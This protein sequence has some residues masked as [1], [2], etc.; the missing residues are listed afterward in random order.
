MNKFITGLKLSLANS[1]LRV[2]LR[3][4]LV[5]ARHLAV[6]ARSG[7]PLLDSVFLLKKQTSSK[8]MRKI[9]QKVTLDLSNGQFLSA[10]LEQFRNVF[11]DLFIDIIRVGEA[12]G[13]LSEN[14]NYLADELKK[15]KE[16]RSKVVGA[17]IY[18]IIVLAA[19]LGITGLLTI[20]IFPKILPVFKS[21]NV[22]LPISTKILIAVSTT[23]TDYGGWV[24]LSFFIFLVI[25][26][27]LIRIEK[28]RYL[29]HKILLY[30]PVIGV[31]VQAVNLSNFCRTLGITLKSGVQAVQAINITSSTL[32][33]LVYRRELATIGVDLAKGESIAKHLSRHS[34]IFPP[35]LS[36]MVEVGE[37]TGN[38]SDTFLYL[39]DF[40]EGELNDFT[41]NMSNILEPILMVTMG[42]IVGFVAISIITPIYEVTRKFG[43]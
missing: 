12:S 18:P 42:V 24:A 41:K 15:K 11:G 17:M 19:T 21:L 13:T 8:S 6:M 14:L 10:S 1:L 5:F 20:F 2:P 38:L 23:L 22:D 31:V 3:E 29:Y 4:Q 34:T 27:V 16:L 30:L 25:F 36:Q 35:L 33:N 26:L 32:S 9:L 37:S 40:Y 39:S 7:M 43:R 28:V